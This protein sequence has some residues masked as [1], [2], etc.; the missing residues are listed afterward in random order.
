MLGKRESI[1]AYTGNT[2][3]I[4]SPCV[5]ALVDD[6]TVLEALTFDTVCQ[7]DIVDNAALANASVEVGVCVCVVQ[8]CVAYICIYYVY[9]R[10]EVYVVSESVVPIE[11]YFVV[12]VV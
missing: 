8:C 3:F 6:G 7:M 11:E 2:G 12:S 1:A 9:T 5:D 10:H 4:G